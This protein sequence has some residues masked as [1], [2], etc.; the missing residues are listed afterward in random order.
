MV[1]SKS[2]GYA[3][4]GVLYVA[5]MNGEGNGKRIQLDEI[6]ESLTVPRFFLGKIMRK[7]AKE[8]I[9]DSGKG[10][11]GG[12]S[13]NEKTMQTTLLQLVEITGDKDEPDGCVLR[14]RKC[15]P[16]KPCP[17]HNETESIR[18]QWNSLLRA[19]TMESLLN[20]A[21]PNFIRSIAIS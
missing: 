19:T 15:N 20:N 12:F 4:R 14:M 18:R 16:L 7:M 1:F 2:F 6:A 8:G 17:M 21:D 3:L 9:V 5:M 11:Y 10:K 13:I